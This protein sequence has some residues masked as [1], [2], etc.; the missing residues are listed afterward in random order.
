MAEPTV[1]VAPPALE[2][3][4]A[5][6]FA[7]AD[8]LVL[9]PTPTAPIDQG[10]RR[11]IHAVCHSLQ[12]RGA[13]IHF[14]YYPAEWSFSFVPPDLVDR[15]R[16]QW[17][18][19]HLLHTTR[20][21]HPPSIGADH[22]ID[23]WWDPCIGAHLQWLFARQ[24]FDAFIVNYTYL[25]KALEFAPPGVLRILDT[26]DQFTGRRALLQA[27]GIAPEFFH[28]TQE[29]EAIAVA[30]ADL[31]W[32]IKEQEAA[33]FRTLSQR[34]ASR[35]RTWSRSPSSRG[36]PVRRTTAPWSSG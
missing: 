14:V 29:E 15:M 3:G 34:R 36:G 25:S 31:V 24:R 33:F 30:R 10:N 22:T 13:R 19:F 23:E 1:A 20:P 28:T 16:S 35:C 32:A 27:Q 17:D 21:H 11:R 9:S 4:P 2:I 6:A 26:H 7:H 8:I 5:G 18:S 12:R